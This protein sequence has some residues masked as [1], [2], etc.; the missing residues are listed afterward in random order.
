MSF[1]P[2]DDCG[3]NHLPLVLVAIFWAAPLTCIAIR[4]HIGPDSERGQTLK[5]LIWFMTAVA[6]WMTWH[7]LTAWY[8]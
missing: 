5:P 7:H 2:C 8:F 1:D 4:R 6:L 3:P